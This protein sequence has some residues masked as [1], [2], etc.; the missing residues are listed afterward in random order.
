MLPTKKGK[1]L[2]VQRTLKINPVMLP[3]SY[4]F[5]FI[6]LIDFYFLTVLCSFWFHLLA[7]SMK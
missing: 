3:I 4:T 5:R 6:Y 1:V 7:E 2:Y